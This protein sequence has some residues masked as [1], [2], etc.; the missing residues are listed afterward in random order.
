MTIQSIPLSKAF[1]LLNH[2]P[3]LLVSGCHNGTDNA[4]AAAWGCPLD[5]NPCRLT[6]VLDKSA[7]TR[8]LIE[9]S[10]RFAVQIPVQAQAELVLAMGRSSR[11]ANPRKMDNVPLFRQAG[12]DVPLVAGCAACCPSRTISRRMICL[13]AKWKRRGQT[14]R[15]SATGIGGLTRRATIGAR[16]IMCRAGSFTRLGGGWIW[17]SGKTRQRQPENGF[18]HFQAAFLSS[19]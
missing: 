7:F 14:M 15:C 17:G 16:C 13:S 3:V 18:S 10:G 12:F 9:Q 2:G 19:Y 4:M 5:Y 6:V 1:R 11:N 8:N